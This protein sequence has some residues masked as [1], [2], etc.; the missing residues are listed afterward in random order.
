MPYDWDGMDGVR[1]IQIYAAW[2]I[3]GNIDTAATSTHNW[4]GFMWSDFVDE[5]RL[6]RCA[7]IFDC[8]LNDWRYYR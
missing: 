1:L 3:K 6:K 8:S 4:G 2:A 7:V 5:C